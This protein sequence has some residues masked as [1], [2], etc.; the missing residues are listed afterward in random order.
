MIATGEQ[1]TVREFA[2]TASVISDMTTRSLPRSILNFYDQP[3][4]TRCWETLKGKK[5]LG[6]SYQLTFTDLVH[7]M[8]EADL[9]WL[10]RRGDQIP[11]DPRS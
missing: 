10:S 11:G 8:V 7:E 2:E 6:W 4:W 1:H 5:K 3:R 9:R